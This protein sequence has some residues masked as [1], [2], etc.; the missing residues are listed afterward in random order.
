MNG[1]KSFALVRRPVFARYRDS[2]L[3]SPPPLLVAS[4]HA[5]RKLAHPLL[6]S[7]TSAF[8]GNGTSYGCYVERLRDEDA[9]ARSRLDSARLERIAVSEVSRRLSPSLRY[10]TITLDILACTFA[11]TRERVATCNAREYFSLRLSIIRESF[12]VTTTRDESYA[13]KLLKSQT[14]YLGH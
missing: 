6:L 10:V 13:S 11:C 8:I 4:R 3:L 5:A 1:R 12:F 2:V 14:T 7:A 9:S